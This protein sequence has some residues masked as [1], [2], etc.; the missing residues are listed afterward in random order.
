VISTHRS[1]ETHTALIAWPAVPRWVMPQSACGLNLI[2][3]W[4]KPWRRLALK[5]R[6][7]ARLDEVIEAILQA[8]A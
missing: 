3:P 6:R 8:T 5:G 7:F 1:R 2:E 4:W